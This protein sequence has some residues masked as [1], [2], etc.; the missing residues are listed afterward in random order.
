MFG[1]TFYLWQRLVR[2]RQPRAPG[3][4]TARNNRRLWLRYVSDCETRVRL[5]GHAKAER[6]SVRLRDVSA[7]GA[8][9]I[10][11]RAFE[12]G[13]ILSLE[14]PCAA[15]GEV[16]L[17]LACVIHASQQKDG[18]WFVGCAFSRELTSADLEKFG[19]GKVTP[20]NEDQRSVIRHDCALEA[21]YRRVAAD[22]GRTDDQTFTAQVLNISS[23]GV[24]LLINDPVEPGELI[25]VTLHDRHG[26]PVREILA[27]VVHSTRRANGQ[28][29]IGCN[30]I[31]E[32]ADDELE[33]LV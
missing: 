9:L 17:M 12:P 13:Q 7:G 1:G 32:L 11:D 18:Q 25:N 3:E 10:T 27:C 26:Q 8:S 33:A 15:D 20:A 19:A 21:T 24:G 22:N 29:T 14:V 28:L 4:T 16:E 31:R 5:D 2:R 30:F 6:V 23:S